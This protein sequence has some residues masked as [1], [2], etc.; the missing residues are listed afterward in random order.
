MAFDLSQDEKNE[1][2]VYGSGFEDIMITDEAG[3]VVNSFRYCSEFMQNSSNDEEYY[4]SRDRCCR[5][6][7][8]PTYCGYD[9]IDGSAENW[10]YV[11]SMREH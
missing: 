4:S 5:C 10:R 6:P 9:S 3:N 1:K 2:F 7:L 11:D 8:F